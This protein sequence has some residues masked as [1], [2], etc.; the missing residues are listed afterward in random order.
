MVFVVHASDAPQHVGRGL[1]VNMAGQGITG[2]G[3]HR[4]DAA[5]PEQLYRLFEQA[6]LG[7]VRVDLKELG[8]SRVG[9]TG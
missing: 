4:D 1:V 5:A 2:I 3:R 9:K 8:H 6:G 7:V